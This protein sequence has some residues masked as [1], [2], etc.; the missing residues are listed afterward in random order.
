MSQVRRRQ[1]RLVMYGAA[2]AIGLS[3]IA[4]A[5]LIIREPMMMDYWVTLGVIT[6]MMIAGAYEFFEARRRKLIDSKLPDLL[7]DIADAQRTGLTLV[8]ALEAASRKDYGP[9]T[10]ELRK[11]VTQMSWGVS[12]ET[13]L[14]GFADRAGTPMARRAALMII[15]VS[16]SGG[17]V[18]RLLDAVAAF[19]REFQEIEAERAASMRGYLGIVYIG[20][21][22]FIVAV[23]LLLNTFFA[24]MT[25]L[26]PT[27]SG[28]M[29]PQFSYLFY[30]RIFYHMAVV[31]AV[32]GGLIAGKL[33]EG[34]V[35]AGLKHVAFL[36]TICLLAFVL[37][38]V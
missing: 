10:K 36:A 26:Q 24:Q 1:L 27:A 16:R 7:R 13:A 34:S 35:V 14:K 21:L 12:L 11:A 19:T 25:E 30:K 9:L 15:E 8:R 17:D 29:Q 2:I 33:G 22:V 6:S 28:L 5:V 38:V 3:L 32:F 18:A 37:F 31:Q 20:L 4:Y 23:V